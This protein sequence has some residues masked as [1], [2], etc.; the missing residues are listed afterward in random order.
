M[1]APLQPNPS[2]EN[3]QPS[4]ES[5]DYFK[6]YHPPADSTQKKTADLL[7]EEQRLLMKLWT[8]GSVDIS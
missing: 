4:W 5:D 2:S 8:E 7:Q 3:K 1:S 6:R